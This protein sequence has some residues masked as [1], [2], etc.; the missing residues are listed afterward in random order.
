MRLGVLRVVT[1][2]QK[3]R[4]KRINKPRN[5]TL[6]PEAQ[7]ALDWLA[8]AAGGKGRASSEASDAIVAHA[9]SKGWQR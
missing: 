9:T 7:E 1:G 6:T 5:L 2:K 3:K 4:P 8:E